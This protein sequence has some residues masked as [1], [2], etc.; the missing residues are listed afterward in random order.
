MTC[1]YFGSQGLEPGSLDQKLQYMQEGHRLA[2]GRTW[3]S[4]SSAL[5]ERIVGILSPLS[6][7]W[8]EKLQNVHKH[9]N[10]MTGAAVK[11]YAT[12]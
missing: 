11:E 4:D 6:T 9:I 2:A 7:I 1:M 5:F 3:P 12:L 8:R 10:N